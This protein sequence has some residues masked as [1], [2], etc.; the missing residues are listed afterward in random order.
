MDMPIVQSGTKEGLVLVVVHSNLSSCQLFDTWTLLNRIQDPESF[1]HF[2]R[3]KGQEILCKRKRASQP[4]NLYGRL[5]SHCASSELSF[6]SC[7]VFPH[8][9]NRNR[10]FYFN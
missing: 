1:R 2:E 5:K 9:I 3:F 6:P 4:F 7:S 8:R 10:I